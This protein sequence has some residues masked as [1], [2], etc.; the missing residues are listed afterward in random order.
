MC[1]H[2]EIPPARFDNPARWWFLTTAD[3]F[4]RFERDTIA[5]GYEVLSR[6]PSFPHLV[7]RRE[8]SG[9][10][11]VMGKPTYRATVAW[12]HSHKER[13]KLPW[14]D[15]HQE[16]RRAFLFDYRR[17]L[18]RM[19][20]LNVVWLGPGAISF[21]CRE[22]S[23]S[24]LVGF[25]AWLERLPAKISQLPRDGSRGYMDA[26]V[27]RF[28]SS[29]YDPNMVTVNLAG[30][31]GALTK[32]QQESW[33]AVRSSLR[34]FLE[35]DPAYRQYRANRPRRQGAPRPKR[36]PASVLAL[37]CADYDCRRAGVPSVSALSM[38]LPAVGRV[39]LLEHDLSNHR[40]AMRQL[41]ARA[42][43]SSRQGRIL[44]R[45]CN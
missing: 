10:D 42:R 32:K 15:L 3:G 6:Q 8:L 34:T 33:R 29:D 12:E 37:A 30:L 39:R 13:P 22:G 35:R 36:P 18:Y 7:V 38:Y 28:E 1:S 26:S 40:R 25:D 41:L 27:V 43:G 44:V 45:R 2:V 4:Q 17:E 24:V 23:T 9:F 16:C 20:L 21:D 5:Q 31:I 11:L 19:G 14:P